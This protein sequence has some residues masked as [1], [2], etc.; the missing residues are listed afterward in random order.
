MRRRERA[1]D[2]K[3]VRSLWNMVYKT[4]RNSGRLER[5]KQ[6]NEGTKN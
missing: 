2:R 3:S 1:K 5:I 4:R 6:Q